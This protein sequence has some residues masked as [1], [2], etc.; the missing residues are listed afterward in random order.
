[1]SNPAF[2][3]FGRE[4]SMQDVKNLWYET[5]RQAEAQNIGLMSKE[6][7]IATIQD[8][9]SPNILNGWFVNADSN[10][11]PLLMDSVA[12]NNGVFNASLNIAYHNYLDGLSGNESPM[13]F[14]T[15]VNTPIQLFRGDRGQKTTT[16]DIF[17]SYTPD[18][19]VAESFGSNISSITIKPID[20]WGSFQ[21]TGEQEYL[22][23]VE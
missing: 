22:I 2:K 18:R 14:D 12:S 8:N 23:P 3:E 21:S 7:A 10:Y 11:K 4:N 16:S 5:R 17:S 1:M 13:S 15:W 9:I 19:S 20:T 6:D